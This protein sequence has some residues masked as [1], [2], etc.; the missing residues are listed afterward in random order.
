MRIT[1]GLLAD[2]ANVTAEG[3]INILGEFNIIRA[4]EL[5]ITVASFTLVFRLEAD[6]NEPADHTFQI[7]LLDEDGNLVRALADGTFQLVDSIYEGVPRRIQ[8]IVPIALAT[9]DRVGTFTFD[10]LVDNQRPP[11]TP[12][13]V[14]VFH[15]PI[16]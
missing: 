16:P 8:G 3:K 6:G 2:A 7:R 10:I 12:A 9:F 11:G 4:P 5:P 13:E 15:V 1:L 14:H